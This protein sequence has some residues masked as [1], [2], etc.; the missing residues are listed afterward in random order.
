M[1][2]IYASQTKQVAENYQTSGTPNTEIDFLFLKPGATRPLCVLAI[3]V[4]GKGGGLTTLSGIA[5]R[6]KHWTSTSATGGTST[7][8]A[9]KNNLAPA[10][11]ATAG[12]GAGGSTGAV[13]S[14]TGGPNIVG[15][16]SMGG[17]GPGGSVPI[18]PDDAPVLDGNANKSADLFSSCPT[19]NLN[20]EAQID[21]QEG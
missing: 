18:N 21:N 15:F 7:T 5:I 13:T 4:Q 1:P 12:M 19:A 9:P 11:V 8:P 14:G 3:R 2:F 16:A 20:F 10:C 6:L 17:S